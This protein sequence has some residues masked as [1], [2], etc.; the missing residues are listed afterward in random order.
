MLLSVTEQL[1]AS[2][3]KDE[4]KEIYQPFG[5]KGANFP[6]GVARKF[7]TG[8]VAESAT[9]VASVKVLD[10]ITHESQVKVAQKILGSLSA[11]GVMGGNQLLGKIA[12]RLLEGDNKP[13]HALETIMDAKARM[14]KYPVVR[15]ASSNTARKFVRAGGVFRTLSFIWDLIDLFRD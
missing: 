10:M 1:E 8:R 2:D 7:I 14:D 15:F 6:G 11:G 12:D 4:K 13:F 9:L 5:K 3:Q